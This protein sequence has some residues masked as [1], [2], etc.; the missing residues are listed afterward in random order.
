MKK[1]AFL[2]SFQKHVLDQIEY[3]L[4]YALDEN[5]AREIGRR[6]CYFH[7]GDMA[8]LTDLKLVTYGLED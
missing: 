2:F 7:C 8:K 5:E 1:K 4:V 6:K 3:I